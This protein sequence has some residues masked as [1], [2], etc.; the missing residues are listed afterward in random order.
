MIESKY[1]RILGNIKYYAAILFFVIIL[2]GVAHV[3][4]LKIYIERLIME[5]NPDIVAVELDYGRYIALTT[6][7]QGEMPYFYRKMA[8]MQKNLADMLGGEVGS[9]MITAVRTAQIM[10]KQVAFIDMDSQQIIKNIKKNMGLLEKTKM[11]GS[12]AFAPIVG[13]KVGKKEVENIIEQEEKYIKEMKK[14]Y[15]GLS[16]AL[17]DD[18]EEFMANNLKNLDRE[19]LKILAFVGDGHL[20]GLRKRLPQAKIIRLKDM[21]GDSRSFS[22]E[23]Y[24]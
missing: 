16:K 22:Y 3:I 24:S 18:R 9:E 13:K 15:P 20:D 17:F 5:E 7:Q 14:K 21:L 12:L 11:Y 10:N 8:E 2:V 19:D 23:I 4:D 6:K 1:Y